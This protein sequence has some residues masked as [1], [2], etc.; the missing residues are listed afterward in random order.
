MNCLDNYCVA[1]EITSIKLC[2]LNIVN[3]YF[4]HTETVA[5]FETAVMNVL[6]I[7]KQ[8]VVSLLY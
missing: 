2:T 5:F 4:L 7:S 8:R 3:R 1:S 6:K